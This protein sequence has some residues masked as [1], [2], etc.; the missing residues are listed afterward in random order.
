LILNL[1]L[2]ITDKLVKYKTPILFEKSTI[3]KKIDDIKS[4]LSSILS[5]FQVKYNKDLEN[6][7]D[8]DTIEKMVD[9][10]EEDEQITKNK[11]YSNWTENDVE[12]WMISKKINENIGN[13]LKPCDGKL[14]Y[15][16]YL[17]KSKTPDYF[18]ESILTGNTT[19]SL[20]D[21]AIFSKEINDLFSQNF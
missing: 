11:V 10:E 15:E 7:S 20:R 3:F 14:L 5:A 17:M 12:N 1:L 6:V 9:L 18:N 2:N 13:A 4:Q 19:F 8:G 21:Y 16:F